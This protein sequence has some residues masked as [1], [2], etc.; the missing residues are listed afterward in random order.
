MR[1]NLSEWLK[2]RSGSD[3][4][5]NAEQ[6][7][8]DFAE[9]IGYVL[10]RWVARR[11]GTTTDKL[12]LAVGHDSRSS[13]PRLKEALI[14]GMK[15]ADCDVLDCG[16]CT[17]PAMF[18]TTVEPETNCDGAVMITASHHPWYKNGFKLITR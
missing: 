13:G 10:A 8:D 4:R 6:L 7:T 14:R 11:Y 12:K 1:S 16:L 18:I 17:T 15:A 3:I 9:R 5:G 2:L